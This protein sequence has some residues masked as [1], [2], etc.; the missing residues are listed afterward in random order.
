MT[1]DKVTYRYRVGGLM[2]CCTKTLAL[3]AESNLKQI[4]QDPDAGFL[5]CRFCSTTMV[6]R[7]GAWERDK[8]R[9]AQPPVPPAA[10]LAA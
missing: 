6:F 9:T 3:A 7:E 8:S 1:E 10:Q 4:E 2:R 5:P